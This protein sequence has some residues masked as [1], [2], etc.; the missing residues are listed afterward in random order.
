MAIKAYRI[1]DANPF[2]CEP[3][4]SGLPPDPLR[5]DLLRYPGERQ[6]Q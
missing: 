5:H 4:L 6:I 2:G 1:G 3:P